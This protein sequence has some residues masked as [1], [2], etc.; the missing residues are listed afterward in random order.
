MSRKRR[1]S[2]PKSKTTSCSW[3]LLASRGSVLWE[4]RP[5]DS[6]GAFE[7]APQ[8]LGDWTQIFYGHLHLPA[9]VGMLPGAGRQILLLG[10]SGQ[11]FLI[12]DG[13]RTGRRQYEPQRIARESGP[14]QR[15]LQP[16]NFVP[17]GGPL[18]L[19]ARRVHQTCVPPRFDVAPLDEPC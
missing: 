15:I 10:L 3:P 17:P 2:C 18:L 12:D 19:I 16:A 6:P 11:V 13:Q 4:Y 7:P 8:I 9:P 5:L 14:S 1:A